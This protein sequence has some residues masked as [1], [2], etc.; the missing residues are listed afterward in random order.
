[1]TVT[2]SVEE[3]SSHLPE[4][5]SRLNTDTSEIVI[6]RDGAPVARLLPPYEVGA[7][8]AGRRVPGCDRG[9]FRVPDEFFDPL[10]DGM[11]EE[12]YGVETP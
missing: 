2:V 11:L 8:V 12:M 7:R 10:P 9:L 5:L 4:L 1:M 6:A 3:A